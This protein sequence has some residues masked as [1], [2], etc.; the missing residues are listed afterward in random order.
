MTGE[1]VCRAASAL[2]ALGFAIPDDETSKQYF[3]K[4]RRK[5]QAVPEPESACGNGVVD[6]QTAALLTAE[7]APAMRIRARSAARSLQKTINHRAGQS[8]VFH[9]D[10]NVYPAWRRSDRSHRQATT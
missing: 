7:A 3:G 10:E 9:A 8:Q 6:T 5:R 1:D 2:K 4:A